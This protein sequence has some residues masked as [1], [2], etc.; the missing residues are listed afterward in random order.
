MVHGYMSEGPEEV[1]VFLG[2]DCSTKAI[3][4]VTL[5]LEE[6]IKV[7]HKWGRSE[8]TFPERFPHLIEDFWNDISRIK[9]I[10][11][12]Q[13]RVIATIEESIYIQNPRTTVQLASVVGCVKFGCYYNGL[14]PTGVDNKSWKKL[15]VGSGN[16]SKAD[17]M[18]FAIE[19]W[20]DVFEEQDFA[21]AACIALWGLRNFKLK[22][23]DNEKS[24]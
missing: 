18:V 16:A 13:C 15:I 14:Y 6:N 23:E 10:R 5:D 7:Q 3:H 17:I 24:E 20:G 11:T 2:L 22:E 9:I 21:D 19:K 8:K 4:S 1:I 12:E